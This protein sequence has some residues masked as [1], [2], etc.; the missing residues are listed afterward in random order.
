MPITRY[1]SAL[2]QPGAEL[3]ER[4]YTLVST[5]V[6]LPE[7]LL[8]AISRDSI[9]EAAF[10][11]QPVG[12]GPF[13][14]VRWDAKSRLEIAAVDSFY[15]GRAKLDRVIWTI[16]PEMQTA[17]QKLLAGE[18]QFLE[19]LTPPAVAQVAKLAAL[20]VE[21]YSSFDYG[22]VRFNLHDG[23]SAHRTR[24]SATARC[25]AR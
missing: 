13:R 24:Y 25:A 10:D 23:A 20:R 4:F 21:P 15:R 22:F 9:R 6:P 2:S 1:A 16:A 8:S 18:A 19:A 14:L 5:L 12:D 3:V 17:T 7:H 11:R